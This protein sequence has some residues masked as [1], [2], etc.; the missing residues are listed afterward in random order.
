M[1]P[2]D[3]SEGPERRPGAFPESFGPEGRIGGPER[4][5][6]GAF[7]NSPA[8]AGATLASGRGRGRGQGRGRGPGPEG[9][10]IPTEIQKL[11]KN[12]DFRLI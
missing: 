11:T 9:G 1:A 8:H 6:P 10:G 4:R 3:A 7:P 2:R 5:G 12:H